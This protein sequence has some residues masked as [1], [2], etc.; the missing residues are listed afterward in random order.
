MTNV[1]Q[2][3][4]GTDDGGGR[5]KIKRNI[6]EIDEQK[7]NGC[8]QCVTACAEGAIQL[9]N[10][11]AR[12]IS[13]NYC[14]GLAACLGECP[15]GALSIVERDADAFDSEA[16]EQHLRQNTEKVKSEI[17][18]NEHETRHTE[19]QNSQKPS[20][21][22]VQS[23]ILPCGCPSTNI[24]MFLSECEESN[25]PRH[26]DAASA[27]THWPIQIR[28]VPPDAAF[29]KKAHLLVAS[30]CTS[31]AYPGFHN[32]FLKGRVVLM[33]CPKFDDVEAYINKFASIFL[34]AGIASITVLI[35]EVPCCS[36][37]PSIIKQGMLLAGKD[38][39]IEIVT[40]SI[41]GKV[42]KKETA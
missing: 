10:G 32:D 40:V 9:V 15:E 2:R 34:E 30:D 13:E 19:Q 7:C 41:T 16:V 8:G 12:L 29:L 39:P 26:T 37:M 6:I 28:L 14:D 38:I 4:L 27:L 33:G 17:H 36:K 22:A 25:K 20:L 5:M 31:V 42:L 35:M 23:E 3:F 18:V 21:G 1:I 24:K 11:K